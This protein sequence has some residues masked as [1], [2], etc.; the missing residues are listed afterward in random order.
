MVKKEIEH[1]IIPTP[2]GLVTMEATI[3]RPITGN[4]TLKIVSAYVRPN[5]PILD[6]DVNLILDSEESTIIIGDLNARSPNWYDRRTNANGRRLCAYLENKNNTYAVGP[7]DPTCYNGVAAPT[8]LYIAILHNVGQQYEIHS[9]NEGDSTH[10]QIVLTLGAVDINHLQQ[11]QKKIINWPNY[12]RIVS[13]NIGAIPTINNI[14]DLEHSVE[15]LEQT[16]TNAIDASSKE[17]VI[18]TINGRFGDIST[19][20]KDLIR[21]KKQEKTESLPYQDTRRQ[22]DCKRV[23]KR[24]QQD[25]CRITK[26]NHGTP[27]SKILWKDKKPISPLHGENSIVYIEQDRA[28]VLKDELER[29]CRNN[30]HPHEDIDFTIQV[31]N[32]A[33]RLKRRKGR[34]G[35]V[36]TPPDE[37]KNLIKM[38]HARKAPGPD[39]ITNKALK[40]LPTKAVVYITNIKTVY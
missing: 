17:E 23:K 10:N 14:A 1:Q 25:N 35:I 26:T 40:D 22:K 36:H 37:I 12:R 3:V 20:L 32:E 8:H 2:D 24:S 15:K 34:V 30:E 38:T 5:G 7:V 28:E 6:E 29:A 31:E 9:L 33:R 4:E 19:E 13:E 21:E 18:K 27:I 39:N 11:R 16:I